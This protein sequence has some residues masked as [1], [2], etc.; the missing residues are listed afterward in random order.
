MPGAFSTD[1]LV[2][3]IASGSPLDPSD[4]MPANSSLSEPELEPK[5]EIPKLA[6]PSPSSASKETV[7]LIKRSTLFGPRLHLQRQQ[8]FRNSLLASV[9]YLELANAADFAA[10]VWNEIPVPRFAAVLM[11]IGGTIALA[12]TSVAVQD[13]RLS[14]RNVKLLRSERRGLQHL[15]SQADGLE[16]RILS[17]RLGV[18][19]RELGT[20]IVDRLAMDLLMGIG[21]VLVGVGTLMAIGGADPKVYKASNLLSGYIGNAVAAAFGV[22]NAVWSVYLLVRFYKHEVAVKRSRVDPA[23]KERIC[24]RF[25]RF[26]GHAFLNGITGL[27][28][29]AGSLVTATRWW[30][31]V[32]LLPCII[33]L[34]FCNY[35]WRRRLGYDRPVFGP[36]EDTESLTQ[37]LEY[38][39]A[40]QGMLGSRDVESGLH[41]APMQGDQSGSL[42]DILRLIEENRML[43][44]YVESLVREKETRRLLL[45]ALP[46]DEAGHMSVSVEDMGRFLSGPH[47]PTMLSHARR[48]LRV[49]GVDIFVHRERYLLELLGCAIWMSQADIQE[50]AFEL[51]EINCEG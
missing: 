27:V 6:S 5:P 17:A 20:E 39:L 45:E 44:R 12:M 33:S 1:T 3:D 9:G 48:F 46:V 7:H 43:E 4:K 21:S 32:V 28:A 2:D 37:S 22:I 11:G 40:M 49:E 23:I 47:V 8:Q 26:G 38:V 24:T 50:A 51:N 34:I 16:A 10:N 13:F 18:E 19:I 31:Y 36:G 29:G 30:G 41:A 25:R 35:F 15:S 14:W 42:E